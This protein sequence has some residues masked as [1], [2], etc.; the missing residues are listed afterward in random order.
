MALSSRLTRHRVDRLVAYDPVHKQ[1][2]QSDERQDPH[3][4]KGAPSS[5]GFSRLDEYRKLEWSGRR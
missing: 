2:D 4:G 3:F 5:V 1:R